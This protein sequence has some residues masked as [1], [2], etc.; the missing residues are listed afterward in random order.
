MPALDAIYEGDL[1][2]VQVPALGGLVVRRGQ[3]IQ[4]AANELAKAIDG[5]NDED[6]NA[7]DWIVVE[8]PVED[9]VMAG[10]L[11]QPQ[12]KP[13]GQAAHDL[14]GAV[15][16]AT[17]TLPAPGED[18]TEDPD[19]AAE[20]PAGAVEVPTTKRPPRARKE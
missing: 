9:S 11:I 12:W 16:V 3:S 7:P 14:L 4:D 15:L 8:V 6:P 5:H 19:T 10:L 13:R 18:Q 1:D 2:E 20:A 17:G